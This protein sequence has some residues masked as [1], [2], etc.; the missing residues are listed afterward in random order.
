M[1]CTARN[2]RVYI[3]RA[4]LRA[5]V[6]LSLGTPS[7]SDEVQ[8]CPSSEQRSSQCSGTLLCMLLA[9]AAVSAL[10]STATSANEYQ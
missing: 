2:L 1:A 5:F 10:G 8:A 6:Y 9:S 4:P 3:T 7:H